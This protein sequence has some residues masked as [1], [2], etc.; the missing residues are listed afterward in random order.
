MYKVT[1]GI[2][3]KIIPFGYKKLMINHI[4]ITGG[5]RHGFNKSFISSK[6]QK[7]FL[8][9]EFYLVQQV[10]KH[11]QVKML[12]NYIQMQQLPFFV[13]KNVLWIQ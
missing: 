13:Q 10:L 5:Y 6:E 12:K 1:K 11:Y 3:F 8:Q 9:Q 7:D 4:N 2:T